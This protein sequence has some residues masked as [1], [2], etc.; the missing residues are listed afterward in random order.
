MKVPTLLSAL[1]L[2]SPA[3]LAHPAQDSA[4]VQLLERDAAVRLDERAEELWKRKG[5]GGGRGGGSSG[6]KG[7]TTSSGYVPDLFTWSEA[8]AVVDIEGVGE[9]RGGAQQT[10]SKRAALAVVAASRSLA[11]QK[12]GSRPAEGCIVSRAVDLLEAT[13]SSLV[14]RK[15]STIWRWWYAESRTHGSLKSGHTIRSMEQS[16][17]AERE[18]AARREE[19][20][21]RLRER[22]LQRRAFVWIYGSKPSFRS[23]H[24]YV[25]RSNSMGSLVE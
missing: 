20:P 15:T 18:L 12:R 19:V 16:R 13:Y 21:W 11:L 8:D 6:G 22:D 10:F 23:W 14:Y 25:L 1:L 24:V 3:V 17:P 4:A 2:L 9:E 7:G 5:G